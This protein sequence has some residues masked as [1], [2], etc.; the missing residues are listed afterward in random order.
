[1][2]TAYRD[3]LAYR[4]KVRKAKYNILSVIRRK[5]KAAGIECIQRRNT[6]LTQGGPV[7]DAAEGY[8]YFRDLYEVNS[9]PLDQMNPHE[10]AKAMLVAV[11]CDGVGK[12]VAMDPKEGLS[13]ILHR[14]YEFV[15][16][17]WNVEQGKPCD[18]A[19]PA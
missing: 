4:E 2:T 14:R 17:S 13:H 3:K 6:L 15:Y 8:F 10:R 9:A 16:G 18:A 12:C 19:V 11:V 5:L 7:P 1:M